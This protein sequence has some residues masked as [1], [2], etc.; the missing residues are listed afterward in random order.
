MKCTTIELGKSIIKLQIWDSAGQ[1]TIHGLVKT[2]F[3]NT[4][5]VVLV[6]SATDRVSLRRIE[7][8]MKQVEE[9]ASENVCKMLLGNKSD[10]EDRCVDY[11]EGKQLA[12]EI[13][14]Q[15]F[16][17]SAKENTNVLEAFTGLV[18]EIRKKIEKR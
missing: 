15:F 3:N 18:E 4:S 7:K 1:D 10:A 9:N 6:Y 14:I 8:W 5:G 16:E 13:G 2:A 12:D 11:S 17:V